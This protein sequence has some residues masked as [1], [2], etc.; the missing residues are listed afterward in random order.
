MRAVGLATCAGGV[1]LVI[2][3]FAAAPAVYAMPV[4]PASAA[5]THHVTKVQFLGGPFFGRYG[6][7]Q[8]DPAKRHYFYEGYDPS[9]DPY[10][11][12]AHRHRHA[13]R[14]LHSR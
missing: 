14:G 13:R 1:A 2:A 10:K 9:L 4:A 7:Y 5:P 11:R 6:Y 8:P 3:L 12:R